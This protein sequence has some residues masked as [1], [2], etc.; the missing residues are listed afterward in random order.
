MTDIENLAYKIKLLLELMD[1]T[2]ESDD[3]ETLVKAKESLCEKINHNEAV[4]IVAMACGGDMYERDEDE[5]KIKELDGLI[6]LLKARTALRE[7][8]SKKATRVDGNSF[9]I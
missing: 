6:T 8:E 3:L 4:M 5:L 7:L 1:C 9:Y 2:F